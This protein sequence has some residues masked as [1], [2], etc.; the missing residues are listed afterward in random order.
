MLGPRPSGG[1]RA[2][3]TVRTARMP[4]R[5]TEA[6]PPSPDPGGA[7]YGGIAV[8]DQEPPYRHP[9]AA[10]RVEIIGDAT[11]YLGESLAILPELGPIDGLMTDP[12]YSSGGQF[13]G[14]RMQKTSVKY[15]NTEHRGLYAEFSGD[16]RDQRSFGYWSALWLSACLEIAR[17]GGLCVLCSDWRQLPTT[18]DA[19][20]AGG[21]V[22]R[23][24]AVWDKTEAS[25]PQRGRY[26]NQCEYLV[27]GSK[28][29]L[30][31][32]GS[33]APG[34][35]RY[36]VASEQK[37]HI[38]G[39]PTALFRDLLQLTEPGEIILDPFMGSGTTGVA[40]VKLGRRFI[41]IE[42]EER[43]FDI[44]CRRI[45]EAERQPDMLVQAAKA[46]E[47]GGLDL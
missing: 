25:R 3:P 17:P 18:T 6:G 30:A 7:F 13:R 15:Q 37:H 23:G 28:G 40:A 45:A 39:K 22:W 20:Q 16:T 47:Q 35:F 10:R 8:A 32:A 14:D 42:I 44:A 38:T 26:R 34:A 36:S 1:G 41:G 12:P 29:A 21:W 43:Y 33:C 19:L 46:D 24:V 31:D 5:P 9:T 2:A 4:P 11:L 27:W